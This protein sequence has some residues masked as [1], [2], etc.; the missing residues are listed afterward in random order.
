VNSKRPV[1]RTIPLVTH[2]AC[3]RHDPGPEHA[4]SPGRL[5]ALREALR[6]DELLWGGLEE[7]GGVPASEADLLRVHT[8]EHV[9]RVRSA[10]EEAARTGMRVWLDADTAV[11]SSSFEAAL[12]AAGCA[13]GAAER[14]LGGASAFALSRP[15]GHHATPDRAM[16]FCLFNNVAVAVR[17]LQAEGRVRDVLVVDWDAHHGNGTQEV[18][19]QDPSVYLIS[20]H[21]GDDYPGTGNPAQ[22]GAGPGRG[23]TRNVPLPHGTGSVEY[24]RRYRRAL[25]AALA[26]FSPELVVVSAG[27]D[28]LS[29]DPEGGFLLE[30]DDLHALTSDLL[31]RLPGR[32]RGIAAVL[33][34]GY[35]LERIG[36]GLT[37]VLR[38]LAGLPLSRQ[39]R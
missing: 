29:G 30:P 38:A 27:F 22:R 36:A 20:L 23:L 13:V 32:T 14:A 34:G 2:P 39:E 4:E 35:A 25:D 9:A 8:P 7:V 16:G 21:L 1:P 26:S 17:R 28:L 19:Y 10:A 15:P 31:E 12:A 33:E 37:A 3:V 6:A 11:G 18:F 5:A 24:R